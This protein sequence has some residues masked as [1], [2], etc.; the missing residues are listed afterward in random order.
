MGVPPG[1]SL[2]VFD[3]DFGRIGMIICWDVTFPQTAR[4]LAQ[5]GAEIIFLPIWE[6]T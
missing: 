4:T 3:T 5:K 1:D 6:V 2:P